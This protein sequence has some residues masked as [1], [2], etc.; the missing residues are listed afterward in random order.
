[1]ALEEELL[2]AEDGR[3]ARS[4]KTSETPSMSFSVT[5]P[6]SPSH[7]ITSARP[8]TSSFPSTLPTKF[9]AGS[10]CNRRYASANVSPPFMGS[11]PMLRSP[12]RGLAT[13]EMRRA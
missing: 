7:T 3:A 5:L 13:L 10:A 4:E 1:V 12:T 6:S 9:T 8:R 2:E 11:L